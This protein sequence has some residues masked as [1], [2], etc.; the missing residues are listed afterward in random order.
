MDY[1][2]VLGVDKSADKKAIKAA[3]RWES[4]ALSCVLRFVLAGLQ[5]CRYNHATVCTGTDYQKGRK[6]N[7]F[8]KCPNNTT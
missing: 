8:R 1:Y 3:Y 4:L 7:K 5:C 6:G 2:S